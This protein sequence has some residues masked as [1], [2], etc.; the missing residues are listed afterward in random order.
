MAR[1]GMSSASVDP[2][3]RFS[4]LKE[5]RIWNMVTNRIKNYEDLWGG[6]EQTPRG[7]VPEIPSGFALQS[8]SHLSPEHQKSIHQQRELYQWAY[9]QSR[10]E[11][12]KRIFWDWSIWRVE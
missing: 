1:F 6:C 7:S 11:V 9:E 3:L 12:H 8:I 5:L 10:L 4:S 2:V